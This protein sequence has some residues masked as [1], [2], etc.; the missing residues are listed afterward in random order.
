LLQHAHLLR[1]TRET[2]ALQVTSGASSRGDCSAPSGSKRP[3]QEAYLSFADRA[4]FYSYVAKG[5]APSS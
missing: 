5:P 2:T 4:G 1:P 3:P